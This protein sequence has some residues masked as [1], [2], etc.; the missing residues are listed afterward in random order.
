MYLSFYAT[1][2]KNTSILMLYLQHY[3]ENTPLE[4]CW[5]FKVPLNAF[6]TNKDLETKF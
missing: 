1:I 4:I 3:A 5:P 6:Y 2:C